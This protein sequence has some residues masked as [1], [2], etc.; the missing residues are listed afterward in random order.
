MKAAMIL[1]WPRDGFSRTSALRREQRS[2]LQV[3]L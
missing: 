2:D 3:P 1:L